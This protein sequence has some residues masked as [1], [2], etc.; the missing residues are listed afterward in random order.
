MKNREFDTDQS[1]VRRD[2]SLAFSPPGRAIADRRQSTEKGRIRKTLGMS[3]P[4]TDEFKNAVLDDHEGILE[5]VHLEREL[6]AAK[7]TMLALS[8]A[9]MHEPSQDLLHRMQSHP[10]N[11][12]IDCVLCPVWR[13]EH[14]IDRTAIAM[15]RYVFPLVSGELYLMTVIYEFAANLYELADKYEAAHRTTKDV[16]TQMTAKRRGVMMIGS[17]EPDLVSS[18]ELKEKHKYRT[19]MK[20][21]GHQVPDTGGWVLTGHFF[22]RVPH[23][24]DLKE[25]MD[26][27]FPGKA[28]N[29]VQFDQV[30]SSGT[31]AGHVMKIIG[32]AAKMPKPLFDAPT[33]GEGRKP[34]DERMG[35]MSVAFG[36]PH[37]NGLG[38]DPDK[39]DLD[40]AIRQWALFVDGIGPDRTFFS[41]ES[42]HA[43][44]WY[45]ASEMLLIRKIDY[46]M[47][48]SGEHRIEMHRDV[49][50]FDRSKRKKHLIGRTRAFRSRKLR[51]DPDWLRL[52]DVS[53]VDPE[54]ELFSF[55]HFTIKP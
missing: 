18:D 25:L 2:G 15:G 50:P 12:K 55:D 14:E 45:S 35:A 7:R 36:G 52:T 44:K 51:H 21:L 27:K 38:L 5:R 4:F 54:S 37:F 42:S 16:V 40:A 6:K 32:Y 1:L 22:I 28:W 31:L 41:I 19:M 26:K 39:F 17:F 9:P 8:K 29:R 48:S 34:Y 49:G 3:G 47:T 11:R 13:H 43:Q 53:N 20:E 30:Y 10:I 33:R 46:D 23:Q 24:A